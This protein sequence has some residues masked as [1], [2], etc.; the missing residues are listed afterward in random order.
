M[1]VAEERYLY[2]PPI[3]LIPPP[4]PHTKNNPR[5]SV[6]LRCSHKAHIFSIP[7]P[8]KQPLFNY[9]PPSA[10]RAFAPVLRA[11]P[12]SKHTIPLHAAGLPRSPHKCASLAVTKSDNVFPK[13]FIHQMLL[14]RICPRPAGLPHLQPPHPKRP[15]ALSPPVFSPPVFSPP[16]FSPPVFSP[17]FSPLA[18]KNI[19]KHK[20][21]LAFV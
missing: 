13:P 7:L 14:A 4:I 21:V 8:C 9:Y 20:K 11:Y 6:T 16:V 12:T 10:P 19:K 3:P 18:Q 17:A 15:A 2:G 1:D 5:F